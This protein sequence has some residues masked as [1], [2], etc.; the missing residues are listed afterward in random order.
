MGADVALIE[1]VPARASHIRHLAAIMRQADRDEVEALT[2][3]PVLAALSASFRRSS[4]CMVVLIDGQPEVIFG[5]GDLNVLTATGAP[6][7]LGSDEA[8]RNR[9]MFLRLSV[10]WRDQLLRRYS[11]LRNV[12]D[13]R[14]AVSIRWLRWL[15]FSFSEPF[16]HRGYDCMMFELRAGDVR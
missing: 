7:L 14:N 9:A 8:V 16:A 11:V 12:V 15:G 6:W 3:R 1:L 4:V 2:G 10:H 13:C 5:V